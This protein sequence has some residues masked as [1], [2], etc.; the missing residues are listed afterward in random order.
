MPRHRHAEA[1]AAIVI[2][3]TYEE[4]GVR[5]QFQ[6]G[7]GDVLLHGAYEAHLDRFAR[8]GAQILNLAGTDLVPAFSHGRIADIDSLVRT[9][10]RDPRLAVSQLYEQ[11]RP[12]ESAM[13]DW[14]AALARHLIRDPACRLEDWARDHGL[15][16][17]TVSRG[18]RKV[19]G[20]TPMLF[21][22]EARAHR[23]LALLARSD[24]PLTAIAADAGF[25]DQAHMTRA[26]RTVTGAPPGAWRRST[27][28][29]TA[30]ISAA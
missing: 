13:P 2:R 26:V 14:P 18:F 11:M 21:R 24:A 12:V 15:A 22:A 5:G 1:Y 23:A 20:I 28:F 3:G 30:S 25:A 8:R 7:S 16:A 29:N 6:V 19:F 27:A 17:E 9:A 10:A 4:C